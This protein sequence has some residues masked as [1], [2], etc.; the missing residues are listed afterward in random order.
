[1]WVMT[2]LFAGLTSVSLPV[3][4]TEKHWAD[5]NTGFAIG[6]Y[7]AVSY[8][9]STG[10]VKGIAEYEVFSG[11]V[12]W[13]FS[14][15]GNYEEFTKHPEIYKPQYAGYGALA[16]SQGKL[17]RG[18]PEIWA[19]ADGK[20]YLFFSAQSKAKWELARKNFIRKAK[21]KWSAMQ[22]KIHHLP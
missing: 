13:R 12:N 4:A 7:D 17:P 16:I 6:G 20:L 22:S 21:V 8:W 3:L 18:N 5:A 9:S 11:E 19:V 10:P 1:M 15:Q 14:N 2:I